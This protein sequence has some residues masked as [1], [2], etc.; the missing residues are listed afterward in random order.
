MRKW[1]LLLIFVF[2]ISLSACS[3]KEDSWYEVDD[4]KSSPAGP[5]GADGVDGVDGNG[6]A[7]PDYSVDPED[8]STGGNVIQAAEIPALEDRK[9]IYESDLSVLSLDVDET[10]LDVL[11]AIEMYPAYIESEWVNETKVQLVIRVESSSFDELVQDLKEEGDQLLHYNKTSE[12][13]TNQYSTFSARLDALNAQHQRIIELIEV[14][15]ELDDIL[16]L[17]NERAELEAELN[18]IGQTLANYDSLV[19]FST[20][21]MSINL[22]SDLSSLLPTSVRPYFDVEEVFKTKIILNVRNKSETDTTLYI[23]VKDNGEIIQQYERDVNAESDNE[24]VIGDLDSGTKYK[25]EVSS[26]EENSLTS[27][28][29]TAFVTTESTFGSIMANTFTTSLNVLGSILRGT[30]LVVVGMLPF[31]VIVGAIGYPLHRF[32]IKPQRIRRKEHQKQSKD[33]SFKE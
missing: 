2:V 24:F 31:A 7:V 5:A 23:N 6:D 1:S 14:A 3:A 29:Y 12:D 25:I 26:L 4:Y 10:Y 20:I 22:I 30:V 33:N 21:N 19:D 32:V 17:E 13:I 16:A 11:E 15:T 27:D 18:A 8:L 9:I 28:I